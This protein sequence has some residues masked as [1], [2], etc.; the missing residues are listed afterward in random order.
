M[1]YVKMIEE[2]DMEKRKL[3]LISMAIDLRKI[4]ER[5]IDEENIVTEKGA[6]YPVSYLI[7]DMLLWVI[8]DP[9]RFKKFLEETYELTEI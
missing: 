1:S 9:K 2:I 5:I 6:R 8:R 3:Y 4:L 7:E